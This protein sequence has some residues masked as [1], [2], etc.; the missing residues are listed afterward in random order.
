[1]ADEDDRTANEDERQRRPVELEPA[2][3]AEEQIP[4]ASEP[5]DTMRVSA[6]AIAKKATA[7]AQ[8]GVATKSSAPNP[9]ATPRP[10]RPRRVTGQQ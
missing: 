5:T 9:V 2:R 1:M 4:D 10:P 7:V 8:A 6:S 3:R